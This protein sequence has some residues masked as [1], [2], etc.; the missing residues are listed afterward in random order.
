MSRH[1]PPVTFRQVTRERTCEINS[2]PAVS[3]ANSSATP[4][5]FPEVSRLGL[6]AFHLARVRSDAHVESCLAA[7]YHA[8]HVLKVRALRMRSS[9]SSTARPDHR[10]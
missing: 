7:V 5:D 3:E 8:P 2:A 4:H 1:L 9:A 6:N 10:L